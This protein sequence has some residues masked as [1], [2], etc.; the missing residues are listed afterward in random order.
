MAGPSLVCGPGAT[1]IPALDPTYRDD[2][3]SKPGYAD[4]N[5]PNYLTAA[6]VD[7]PAAITEIVRD[8]QGVPTA[9]KFDPATVPALGSIGARNPDYYVYDA[10]G[11]TRTV[12]FVDTRRRKTVEK[13]DCPAQGHRGEAL[14]LCLVMCVNSGDYEA[15]GKTVF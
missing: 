14:V 13:H 15:L 5:P 4:A 12:A 11:T 9:L 1:A 2:F 7:G 6:K 8:A 3:W 10:A